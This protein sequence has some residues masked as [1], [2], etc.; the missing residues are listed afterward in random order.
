MKGKTVYPVLAVSRTVVFTTV[1]LAT[2]QE[3]PGVEMLPW[4]WQVVKYNKLYLREKLELVAQSQITRT[5]DPILR[6][7]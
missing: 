7:L 5:N 1:R 6:A 3:R 2:G 4:T